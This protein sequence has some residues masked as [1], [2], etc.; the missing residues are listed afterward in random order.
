M[1]KV[2]RM[3][4]FKIKHSPLHHEKKSVKL[5]DICKLKVYKFMY[6]FKTI[7]FFTT[8]SKTIVAQLYLFLKLLHNFITTIF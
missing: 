7:A 6:Q 3:D 4:Y 5:N 2:A 8:I 1:E